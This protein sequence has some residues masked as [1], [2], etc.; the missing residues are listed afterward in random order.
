MMGMIPYSGICMDHCCLPLDG[1]GAEGREWIGGGGRGGGKGGRAH[2]QKPKA[3]SSAR[4][5]LRT[6]QKED[7]GRA[8]REGPMAERSSEHTK[9]GRRDATARNLIGDEQLPSVV[10]RTRLTRWSRP[11]RLTPVVHLQE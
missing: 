7:E 9:R 1:C 11:C 8:D 5:C 4:R 6:W 10:V 2:T 3:P